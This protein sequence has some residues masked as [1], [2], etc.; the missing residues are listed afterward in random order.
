LT[1]A[2][3]AAVAV[4]VSVVFVRYASLEL[5]YVLPAIS[6]GI[7]RA[8]AHGSHVAVMVVVIVSA[9]LEFIFKKYGL[10]NDRCNGSS[11]KDECNG[12]CD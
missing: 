10:S 8:G 4:S 11:S 7:L 9:N 3:A 6:L 1:A 2:A 12:K 5:I